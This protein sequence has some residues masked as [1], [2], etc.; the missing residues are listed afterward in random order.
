MKR[1]SP[2]KSKL[3]IK[4]VRSPSHR[5]PT[6]RRASANFRSWVGSGNVAHFVH[7]TDDRSFCQKCLERKDDDDEPC[8]MHPECR[9]GMC[10]SHVPNWVRF[11]SQFPMTTEQRRITKRWVRDIMPGLTPRQIGALTDEQLCQIIRN[12]DLEWR[13]PFREPEQFVGCGDDDLDLI[14]HEPLSRIP[15]EVNGTFSLPPNPKERCADIRGVVDW[16]GARD[17]IGREQGLNLPHDVPQFNHVD[18]QELQARIRN[19]EGRNKFFREHFAT[20]DELIAA[21]NEQDELGAPVHVDWAELY[22][23]WNM[24]EAN[25]EAERDA[26]AAQAVR[27]EPVWRAQ[28]AHEQAEWLRQ[29]ELMD[30]DDL[31]TLH[32]AI[33]RRFMDSGDDDARLCQICGDKG[34]SIVHTGCRHCFMCDVCYVLLAEFHRWPA[35]VPC[36]KCG[37]RSRAVTIG[38]YTALV[39]NINDV[40]IQ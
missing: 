6:D 12:I 21:L 8:P 17:R 37:L 38:E 10:E 20:E 5:V 24:Q 35:H 18:S 7:P 31:E 28:W 26:Q 27:N 34:R 33:E 40:L 3:P 19:W 25:R 22:A 4:S 1:N 9:V 16:W 23:D 2:T 15:H 36:I 29:Q 39:G 32:R 30:A 11:C 14:T 13:R